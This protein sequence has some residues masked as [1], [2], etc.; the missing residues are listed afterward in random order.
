MQYGLVPEKLG[1]D[2]IFVNISAKF[3]KN[4]DEL[5]DMIILEAEVM[6]L[7]ADPDQP[8]AGSVIEARLDQGKG[9]LPLCWF[10][11]EHF[12]LVIQSLLVIHLVECGQ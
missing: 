1:G 8:A 9:L 3:G 2:T 10:N 11:K 5:L 12:T 6:E 7:K 4:I